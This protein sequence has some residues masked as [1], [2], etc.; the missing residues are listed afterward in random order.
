[1]R[2]QGVTIVSRMHVP[3]LRTWPI[4]AASVGAMYASS[5]RLAVSCGARW[6]DVRRLCALGGARCAVAC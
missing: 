4:P 1:M 2:Q 6:L 5:Q 3:V